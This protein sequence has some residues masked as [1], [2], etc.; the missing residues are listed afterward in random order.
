MHL[1]GECMKLGGKHDVGCGAGSEEA[2][3]GRQLPIVT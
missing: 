3:S 1:E 2:E